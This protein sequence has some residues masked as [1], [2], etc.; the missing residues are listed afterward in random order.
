M[1]LNLDLRCQRPTTSCGVVI[2]HTGS[3]QGPGYLSQYSEW[4]KDWITWVS[5][6]D[7]PVAAKSLC[8]LRS[9][10]DG[11][12]GHA[13]SCL[14]CVGE[15]QTEREKKKP[16]QFVQMLRIHGAIPLLPNAAS[17]CDPSSFLASA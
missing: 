17:Y 16:F 8:L 14:K 10:H 13:A 1:G 3:Q 12:L 5:R 7:S 4:A 6:W 9:G 11:S 2:G 15:R